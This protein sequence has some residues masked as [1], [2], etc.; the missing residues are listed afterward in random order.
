MPGSPEPANELALLLPQPE[1]GL[2]ELA[3]RPSESR[4][5][6][7]PEQLWVSRLGV[8]RRTDWGLRTALRGIEAIRGFCVS[9]SA[10]TD[11]SIRL[12][13]QVF[14]RTGP[15]VGYRPPGAGHDTNDRKYVFNIWC[16]FSNL[17]RGLYAIELQAVHE[18]G[19]VQ[20]HRDL[21]VIEEP[22]KPGDHPNSDGFIAGL[23]NDGRS[24]PERIEA[25]PSVVRQARRATFSRSPRTVLV[26]RP[27]QLG[28][29]VTSISA[30][31][32]LRELL[33]NARL[34]GLLSEANTDLAETLN[35]FDEIETIDFAEDYGERRRTL[36]FDKQDELRRRLGRFKFDVA[37]DL[38][39][40]GDS[41]PLLAL[42]GAP[43]VLG[44]RDYRPPWLSASIDVVTRDPVGGLSELSHS[45]QVQALVEYFG[46]LLGHRSL[47][48]RRHD[49][50][51]DRLATYGLAQNEAYAV[52]HTGARLKFSRWPHHGALAQ[53]IIE[54]TPLKVVMMTDGPDQYRELPPRLVES[55]RFQVLEGRLP[56]DEFDALLSFCTVFVGND[57]GPAHLAS[58]RGANVINLYM[59]RHAWSEWG[60]EN[61]GY[62]ISRKVPCAGCNIHYDQNECGKDFSCISNISS[63]EVFNVVKRLLDQGE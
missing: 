40:S 25:L 13:G 53:M 7:H 37:I 59:A 55:D 1:K 11:L 42:S 54:N 56:F 18:N 41:R 23:P 58:L 35:I 5:Y 21:V 57:S 24:L 17:P 34:I 61:R 32:R 3:P 60:H 6:H 63:H 46:L 31:R 50:T 29:L 62:I 52:L 30:I 45:G 43:Y 22:P 38:S 47:V 39:V 36:S 12:N 9:A 16:D 10:V 51:R 8:Q 15:L 26:I 49:L 44:F 48:M 27:D 4:V 19:R 2:S 20:A 14:S 33:P 28:D